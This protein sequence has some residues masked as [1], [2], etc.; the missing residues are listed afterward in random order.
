M[1]FGNYFNSASLQVY[2][3][4]E[5]VYCMGTVRIYQVTSVSMPSD[6][7]MRKKGHGHFEKVA[8]LD[9][10][11]ISCTQWQDSKTV[12]LLST[13]AG[14]ESVLS[15]SRWNQKEKERQDTSCPWVIGAYN[16]RMGGIDPLD[17]FISLYCPHFR[18]FLHILNLDAVNAV[19]DAVT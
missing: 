17:S 7:D 16:K 11:Q 14:T 3:E 8:T 18:I 4:K 6:K 2:L 12:T 9:G 15:V 1:Y 13:F 5:D 19:N 10:V